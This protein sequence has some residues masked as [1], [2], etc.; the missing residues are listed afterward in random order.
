[1]M[2]QQPHAWL[3]CVAA[4]TDATSRRPGWFSVLVDPQGCA[5]G[6]LKGA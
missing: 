5:P 4:N 6:V 2:P 3:P 1:M